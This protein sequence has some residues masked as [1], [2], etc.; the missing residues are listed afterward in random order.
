MDFPDQ[1]QCTNTEISS[2]LDLTPMCLIRRQ[3][4]QNLSSPYT[5]RPGFFRP[6]IWVKYMEVRPSRPDIIAFPWKQHREAEYSVFDGFRVVTLHYSG[7]NLIQ[8][9][10]KTVWKY[11][12]MVFIAF[13]ASYTSPTIFT[14][15]IL[16]MLQTCQLQFLFVRRNVLHSSAIY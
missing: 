14:N 7:L 8:C 10:C 1:S 6:A 16:K 9:K 15:Y 5:E 3:V 13:C 2:L 11:N 4:S 12:A